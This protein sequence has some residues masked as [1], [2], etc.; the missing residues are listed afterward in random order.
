MTSNINNTLNKLHPFYFQYK[1]Y[2]DQGKLKRFRSGLKGFFK[3]YYIGELNE[4]DKIIS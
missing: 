1:E 2:Y 3:T 4:I